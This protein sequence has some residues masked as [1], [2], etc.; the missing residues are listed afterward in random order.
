MHPAEHG[1]LGEQIRRTR[2][3]VLVAEADGFRQPGKLDGSERVRVDRRR[4]RPGIAAEEVVPFALRVIDAHVELIPV[5]RARRGR[6][7]VVGQC[8]R[9]R[10]RIRVHQLGRHRVPAV[11]R[12]DVAGEGLAR[13]AAA[14]DRDR[15]QRVVDR[16]DLAEVPLPHLRGRHGVDEYAPQLL[17][18]PVVVGEEEGL[19]PD[20]RPADRAA[21][22]VLLERRFLLPGAVGEEV[23]GVEP[24]VAQELVDQRR[25]SCCRRTW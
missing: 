3:G 16:P 20:N 21:E 7:Q 8:R 24:G 2:E 9:G 15:R 14:G 11:L 23:V 12:N 10:H 22:L 5:L 19:V 13:D 1:V 18:E 17:A 4:L 6:D 25:E